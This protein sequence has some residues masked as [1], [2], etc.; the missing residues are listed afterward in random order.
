M[1]RRELGRSG[2]RLK[3]GSFLWNG[4]YGGSDIVRVRFRIF[5][6]VSWSGIGGIITFLQIDFLH[7]VKS[8]C[9]T[10]LSA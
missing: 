5:L 7:E 10:Y 3:V 6:R 1:V 2:V 4:T 8:L 9:A